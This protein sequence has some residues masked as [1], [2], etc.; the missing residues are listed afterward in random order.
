M[1]K[2]IFS[3]DLAEDRTHDPLHKIPTLPRRHKSRLIPQGSTSVLC[4]YTLWH[5]EEASHTREWK[6]RRDLR[7]IDKVGIQN[8]TFRRKC[9]LLGPFEAT[10]GSSRRNHYILLALF[11][12]RSCIYI[13]YTHRLVHLTQKVVYKSCKYRSRSAWNFV[14]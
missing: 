6:Y 10:N 1:K 9:A 8:G 7:A 11:C 14:Q 2:N 3:P 13:I 4:T 5:S 12:L